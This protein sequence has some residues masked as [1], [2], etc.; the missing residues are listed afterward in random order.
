MQGEMIERVKEQY[1]KLRHERQEAQMKVVD[2]N[3]K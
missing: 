1:H 3:S 2:P